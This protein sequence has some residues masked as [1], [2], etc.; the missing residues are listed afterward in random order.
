M[1]YLKLILEFKELQVFI[2]IFLGLIIGSLLNVINNRLPYMLMYEKAKFVKENAKEVS[3]E[4]NDILSKY[5][6]F[7]LFFPQ[8]R[9]P[10]C[11]KEIKFYQNIPILSYLFLRGKCSGCK[12]KISLEYP[13][14]E[15][16]HVALWFCAYSFFGFTIELAFILFLLTSVLSISVIDLKFQIIPDT[17]QLLLLL[18][19]FYMSTLGLIPI[20]VGTMIITSVMVY[21][22][23]LWFFSLYEYL[24]GFDDII[25]GRG[26]IKYLAVIS[27]WIGLVDL[28]N[29]IIFAVIFSLIFYIGLYLLKKQSVVEEIT[30]FAPSISISFLLVFFN[31]IPKLIII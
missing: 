12:N 18:V 25:F 8:S 17:I 10:K 20:S 16:L 1:D 24:R 6:K 13:I 3:D 29:V 4:V 21:F 23:L 27:A 19:A 5:N 11:K 26:D 2:I 7:N 22:G 9:C 31:L 28:L 15:F 14:V 30:P